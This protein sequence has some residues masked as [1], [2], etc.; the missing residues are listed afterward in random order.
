MLKEVKEYHT[1]NSKIFQHYFVNENGQKYGPAK[2]YDVFGQIQSSY[3]LKNN[4]F[5]GPCKYY[6]QNGTISSVF[7]DGDF[8]IGEIIRHGI[9]IDFK[10]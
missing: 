3:S 1:N 6:N 5:K 8:F 7:I 9:C 4:A 10:Y 2:L